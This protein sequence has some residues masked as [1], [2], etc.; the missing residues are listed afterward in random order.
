MP[1]SSSSSTAR[2][3]ACSLDTSWRVQIASA[4]CQP[5]VKAGL[6]EVSG[7]C[8][9]KAIVLPRTFARSCSDSPIS[10]PPWQRTEPVTLAFLG[11]RPSMASAT[12]DLPDP[13]SP[14]MPRVSP[15]SRVKLRSRTAWTSLPGR[16]VTDRSVAR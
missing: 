12:V 6:S 13:D 8:G 4:T 14:T 15:G 5:T 9:M 11:S 10:S 7:S 2:L 16:E 3:C 1:T